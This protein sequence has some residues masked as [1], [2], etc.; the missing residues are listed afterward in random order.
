MIAPDAAVWRPR[1]REGRFPAGSAG[2][3][4][5]WVAARDL[6]VGVGDRV[7]V[8]HPLRTGPGAFRTATT[9]V[10]V[11]GISS[12]P[13]RF[14]A[15]MDLGQA[16]LMGL[17]GTANTLEIRPAAGARAVDVQRAL[18]A[19][20]GVASVQPAG[21]TTDAATGRLEEFLDI[22][23]F[24]QSV[25]LAITVLIAFNGTSIN[26]EE[27]RREHATMLAFGV[28]ARRVVAQAVV[29]SALLGLLATAAGLVGGLAVLDWVTGTIS[30]DV[31]PELGVEPTLGAGSVVTAVLVGV[32]AVAAAPLL[33]AGRLRRMDIPSTLRVVE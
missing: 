8:T 1:V 29:E 6:G 11:T 33:G 30:R 27:R 26:S 22:L 5:S 18:L 17:A 3:V 10:A 13:Y 2:I 14:M 31:F 19:R 16:S 32:V 25:V 12:S 15:Y 21:A 23:R 24:A 20:P 7:A 28:P 4:L 9:E